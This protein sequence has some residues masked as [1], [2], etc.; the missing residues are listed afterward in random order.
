MKFLILGSGSFAGQALFADLLD[1]GYEVFGINRS[2]PKSYNH[3]SWIKKY[4]T[5]LDKNWFEINLHENPDLIVE[6]INFLQPTHIIDF[7]G[8]G[9]VAQSWNDPMLWY[10]T[11]LAKK[12]YILEA[13]KNLKSLEKYVRA[14]T[15]E[16]YGSSELRQKEDA[17]FCPSTPYAVSHC[18][19]D[20]HLRCLGKNYNFPFLIGRFSNFYGEGQ[21]LY[22]VIPKLILSIY[23]RKTF[24][25]DGDGRSLRSF[26]HSDDICSAFKA[27]LFN[28]DPQKEYNFSTP[29]EISIIDLVRKICDHT[30]TSFEKVVKFGPDRKGKDF[31]YRMD[32]KKAAKEL[33]WKSN[34]SLNQGIERVCKWIEDNNSYLSKVSWNYEHKC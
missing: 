23:N 22:R 2:I 20:Y 9:M 30:N 13:I 25:I 3:W 7:M 17:Y 16:V 5:Q 29:E 33:G 14:S 4:G 28:A 11:N 24:T 18:A 27:L 6:K 19:V 21:Q 15:P 32:Y 31:I 8:Q 34:I 12:S 1:S 10:E 26:I